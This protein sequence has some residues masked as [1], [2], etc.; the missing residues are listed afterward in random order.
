MASSVDTAV[1]KTVFDYVGEIGSLGWLLAV[2]VLM[3]KTDWSGGAGAWRRKVIFF[4]EFLV[5][6][7]ISIS[8]VV[9]LSFMAPDLHLVKNELKHLGNKEIETRKQIAELNKS[10]TYYSVTTREQFNKLCRQGN[11]L[12]MLPEVV[13]N[14]L[15]LSSTTHNIFEIHFDDLH[16]SC[17]PEGDT[18]NCRCNND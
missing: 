5:L 1:I 16:V 4:Y 3:L 14:R 2:L 13:N 17:S 6:S 11:D 10:I 15:G 18:F 12:F 8:F 9:A 7:F